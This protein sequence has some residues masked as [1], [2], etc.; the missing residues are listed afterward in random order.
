MDCLCSECVSK[1]LSPGES[2]HNS[3]ELDR[4]R[5]TAYFFTRNRGSRIRYNAQPILPMI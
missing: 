5:F 4:T 3:D 2:Q 1:S